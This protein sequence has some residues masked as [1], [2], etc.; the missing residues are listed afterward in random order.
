MATKTQYYN[1]DK[2]GY[3]EVA[4][5]EVINANMDK[6][7]TQMRNNADGV[8]F[9]EAISSDAYDNSKSYAVGDYCIYNNKLYRCITAI[10]SA[11]VFNI[12]KWE[13]TTLGNEV[14]RLNESLGDYGLDNK[15]VEI[16]QGSI[17]NNGSDTEDK[18]RVKTKDYLYVSS[19]NIVTVKT[20]LL[21]AYTVWDESKTYV[22]YSSEWLSS[23]IAYEATQNCYVRIKFKKSDDSNFTPSQAGHVGVY[24]NNSIDKLKNDL[25]GLSFSVSGTTL[26]ITDGTNT[27]TLQ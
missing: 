17:R 14:N 6:I 8:N 13:Q 24:I 23:D 12:A 22:I 20:S 9:A 21:I 19:G 10:E 3:D 26:S 2:P 1:L 18:N 11:E 27:W 5:I 16:V 7:D 4:D 15:C 25:G